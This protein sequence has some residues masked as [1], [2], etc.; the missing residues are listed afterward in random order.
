M[1]LLTEQA[2]RLELSRYN[3]RLFDGLKIDLPRHQV[4]WQKSNLYPGWWHPLPTGAHILIRIERGQT[5]AY[6]GDLRVVIERVKHSGPFNKRDRQRRKERKVKR[7]QVETMLTSASP[8][9]PELS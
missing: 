1:K 2:L 9:S 3:G 4:M 5:V 6:A 8:Q 7:R